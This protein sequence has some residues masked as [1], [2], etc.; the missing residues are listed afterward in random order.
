MKIVRKIMKWLGIG[1]GTLL[2]LIIL[3]SLIMNV[4]FGRELRQTLA[5]QKAEGRALTIAE[6]Q[7]TP[8]PDDQNVAPLFQKAAELMGYGFYTNPPPKAAPAIKEFS[9][10]INSNQTADI[11]TWPAAHREALPRL[12]QAPEMQQL[13]TV[14][15]EASQKPGYNSNLKYEAGPG[16]ILPNLGSVRQIARF[17]SIKAE[18]TAQN[19][20]TDEAFSTVQE[21]LKLA[22]LLNQQPT[23]ISQLVRIAC[24]LIMIDCMERIADKTD[25][26]ADQARALI[27]EL[28]QHTD[29][30]PWIR[31]MDA[32]RVGIGLWCFQTLQHGSFRD[33]NP[34]LSTEMN[35]PRW[36]VWGLK[37]P[38]APILK[39]DFTVYL[40]LMSQVQDYYKVP[41]WKAAE[42]IRNHPTDQQIPRY[43]I[44]TRLIFP[45]LDRVPTRK[46][47]HDAAIAVARVG[48]GLKL[49]KQKNGAYPD[50]LDKLA[51][52]FL[53]NIPVDPF[54]GKAL[55]YR[56]V[57][58]GFMLYSLG[59]NQQDDNGTPKPTGNKVTGKEPYDIV[60]KCAR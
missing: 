5:Q 20:N 41:Y 35:V 36:L 56:K 55:I 57:D 25:V 8:V 11:S 1:I 50:T 52:E 27:A 10:L 3:A 4:I 60:W 26:P 45:S 19:G 58:G 49:F 51:P 12:I 53:E 48:L 29:A 43:C 23:L 7:P 39:K 38:Y 54:T 24:D 14:L 40:K 2:V 22:D 21:E 33:L 31:A 18:L 30:T 13:F 15:R 46:A 44:L 9:G 16:M 59:P 34:L 42:T 17:L 37:Y 28:A 6:I 47:E 32:E